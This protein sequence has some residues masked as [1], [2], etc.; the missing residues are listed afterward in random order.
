ME[1]DISK[2]VV[3]AAEFTAAM[4][5]AIAVAPSKADDPHS[6]IQLRTYQD[7]LYVCAVREGVTLSVAVSTTMSDII[8]D[9]DET[10][11]ITRAEARVL[12]AMKM[13]KEDP[14]DDPRVGLLI[15][16]HSVRRTD[17]SGL[18]LG[19]RQV[20]VCRILPECLGPLPVSFDDLMSRRQ[21][22]SVA[23]CG[24]VTPE[25]TAQQWSLMGR[26]A[27]ALDE[28]MVMMPLPPTPQHSTRVL[29][30]SD[31]VC[32]S[33]IRGR[34]QSTEQSPIHEDDAVLSFED[35]T[36]KET[37]AQVTAVSPLRVV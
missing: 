15:G 17:E 28:D 13:N 32:M 27:L 11:E 30:V 37:P 3:D 12:S 14:D 29:L 20:R 36:I 34:E 9:R 1:T 24:E 8:N 25:L 31:R 4:R 33:V 23:E 26:V 5:A 22:L 18:G 35:T 16:E 10:V 19:I 6:V 7:V 2:I 21:E